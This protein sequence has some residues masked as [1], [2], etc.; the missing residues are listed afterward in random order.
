MHAYECYSLVCA[1]VSN[2]HLVLLAAFFTCNDAYFVCCVCRLKQVIADF[3][4][5]LSANSRPSQVVKVVDSK[6]RK[7]VH[8]L[9]TRLTKACLSVPL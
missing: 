9:H 7:S 4:E 6:F 5:E 2:L 8:E 3:E 1:L